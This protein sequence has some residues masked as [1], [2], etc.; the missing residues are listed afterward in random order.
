MAVFWVKKDSLGNYKITDNVEYLILDKIKLDNLYDNRG[1][2][3]A[4]LS[5]PENID[6]PAGV[7]L[8]GN[9]EF[10]PISIGG[11]GYAAPLYFTTTNSIVDGYRQLNYSYQETEYII[12]RI[13]P[14]GETLLQSYIYDG[15]IDISSI[16]A[17][18]W[19]SSFYS[20]VATTAGTTLLRLKIY[21]RDINNV[22]TLLF[23]ADSTS[24]NNTNDFAYFRFQ[25]TEPVFPVNTTD[26][27]VIKVY[28]YCSLNIN[29]T[30]YTKVGG[31]NS[32][33]IT[34]PLQIR[35]N[36]LRDFNGDPNYQHITTTEKALLHSRNTDTEIVSPDG[37]TTV[38]YTD[39]NGNL[40]I[41]GDI[42]LQGEVY[43]TTAEHLYINDAIIYTRANATVAL[44]E[45]EYT[46]IEAILYDGT[47]NGRLVFDRNGIA[48][49]GDTGEEQPLATRE[50]Y[51]IDSGLAEWDN[52][53]LKFITIS[54]TSLPISTATQNALDLKWS[55]NGNILG[56]KKTL[57]SIDNQDFGIITNNT[58][59]ITV[60]KDG[61]VGI[62]TTNPTARL[63]LPAGTATA[64]TEPLKFTS[65]TL[66][67]T[68]EAGAVEYNGSN[69]YFTPSNTRYKILLDNSTS[70]KLL[71]GDGTPITIGN[72]LT[73]VD[74]VLA[75]SGGT[76]HDPVTLGTDQNGLSLNGQILSLAKADKTTTGA[77]NSED[78]SIFAMPK[79]V[80][81]SYIDDL[82]ALYAVSQ[83]WVSEGSISQTGKYVYIP[84][85][86]V[87]GTYGLL[88][89]GEYDTFNNKQA[90]YT[91]LATLGNLSN[92][93]GSLINDGSGNLS[94]SPRVPYSGAT[95]NVDLGIY[96][97]IANSV[98][99]SN[100]TSSI[101]KA[102]SSGVL[103]AATTDDLIPSSQTAIFASSFTIDWGNYKTVEYLTLTGACSLVIGTI[104]NYV[105]R[106]FI[107]GNYTLT[108]PSISVESI[109]GDNYDGTIINCIDF[110]PNP[111]N[112]T[113]WINITN[114][115]V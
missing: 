47:N 74:G 90:A 43:E 91:I 54:K 15:N 55:F 6:N 71:S 78:F 7:F 31:I 25:V 5:T 72:N 57:G 58:E 106:I 98:Q 95:A 8:N 44:N 73:L 14:Q 53:T 81:L 1:A 65:G 113:V 60:L 110:I 68:P 34:T 19:V 22:E 21:S 66:L 76:S 29:Q 94:W 107:T 37:N 51:P 86:S 48:R 52:T 46:G 49:V 109:T 23:S 88:T 89:K 59:R 40:Y 82:H 35:H 104:K 50:E 11:G 27:L 97:I 93:N 67:T 102:S 105:K 99:Q 103:I 83:T 42:I 64:N 101:V 28:G 9:K 18:P 69:L 80:G 45:G 77:I 20:K 30:I 26:R 84:L 56:A 10:I 33:Y 2:F 75:A 41:T 111:I 17:G 96:T 87:S 79:L 16:P 112:S 62:G 114:Q 32:A 92:S 36:S 38:A 70:D 3:E 63:H 108:I 24:I 13:L 115:G 39:N 61:N 4:W 85:V 100:V 12:E